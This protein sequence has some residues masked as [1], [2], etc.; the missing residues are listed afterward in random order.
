VEEDRYCMD[1]LE[2]IRKRR[3]VREY[4]GASIPRTDLEKIIDAG[5]LAPSGYNEQPW[6]FI[7]ITDREMINQLKVAA[8]WMEKAAAIIA[9]VMDPSSRWWIED[10]SAAIENILIACT[11]LGYGSC[12]LEGYTLPLEEEFKVLLGIPE[13]K[14]LLTL[15]PVGVPAEWPSKEKKPLEEVI[16]WERYQ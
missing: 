5:R 14:R 12:W 15:I 1:A 4:T 10:G 9:V 13:E 7:V 3:S 16:H 11:A 2:A 8:E 6:E